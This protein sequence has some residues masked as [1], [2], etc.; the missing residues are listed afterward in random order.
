MAKPLKVLICIAVVGII[1]SDSSYADDFVPNRAPGLWQMSLTQEE[2]SRTHTMKQCVGKSTDQDMM[3]MGLNLVGAL[4]QSCEE[5]S[6]TKSR[7]GFTSR[8][9][10][11]LM[12]SAMLSEGVFIGDHT[13]TYSGKITTT[14]TPPLFGRERQ[15]ITVSAQ[16]IGACPDDMAEGDIIG[17]G[18]KR[19]NAN[20]LA[21]QAKQIA[22]DP[23]F[24]QAQQMMNR[25]EFV[26]MMRKMQSMGP[27]ER[28][29]LMDLMR[30]MGHNQQ[31]R[32]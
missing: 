30:Q 1:G 20:Q 22:D 4:R 17:D 13:T 16:R 10:C 5:N 24:R 7:D 21:E 2:S 12:G 25:P 28:R 29:K 14:Y 9:K 31:P 27:E 3:Q 8:M 19:I 11:Q 23:R 26:N 15:V 32:Q 6:F 18:G